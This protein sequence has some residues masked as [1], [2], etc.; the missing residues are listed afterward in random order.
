MIITPRCI[1]SAR[2]LATISIITRLNRSDCYCHT[3]LKYIVV[4]LVQLVKLDDKAIYNNTNIYVMFNFQ[5]YHPMYCN[6]NTSA[7]LCL[8]RIF[9]KMCKMEIVS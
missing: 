4:N 2:V 8:H 1:V 9:G 3:D 5:V 6:I 7:C